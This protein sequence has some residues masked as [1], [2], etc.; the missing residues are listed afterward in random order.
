M[1]KNIK[2]INFSLKE[3]VMGEKG[4]EWDYLSCK[5]MPCAV[6]DCVLWAQLSS[7]KWM[8]IVILQSWWSD[9]F[10]LYASHP[11]PSHPI[12]PISIFL[13][14]L[15]FTFCLTFNLLSLPRTYILCSFAFWFSQASYFSLTYNHTHHTCMYVCIP[16][17]Q[18]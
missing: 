14:T 11:I 3:K 8:L 1:V 6:C 5:Q 17:G 7:H 13:Y 15:T 10:R 18:W 16:S 9:R 12:N 2:Y 4:S